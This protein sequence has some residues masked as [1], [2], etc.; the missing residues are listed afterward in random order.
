MWETVLQ[1][2]VESIANALP[3]TRVG[4]RMPG[5]NRGKKR[6]TQYCLPYTRRGN[7]LWQPVCPFLRFLPYT[8]GE[9][10][11]LMTRPS[12]AMSSSLRVTGESPRRPATPEP[13]AGLP[14]MYGGVPAVA[15]GNMLMEQSSLH[16][17]GVPPAVPFPMLLTPPFG[18]PEASPH[19]PRARQC[20]VPVWTPFMQEGLSRPVFCFVPCKRQ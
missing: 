2:F 11:T 4:D 15:A 13:E 10:P 7:L 9:P 16:Y 20:C 12:P 18:R 19:V 6:K 3:H 14:Y 17:G 8:Y 1:P 5:K